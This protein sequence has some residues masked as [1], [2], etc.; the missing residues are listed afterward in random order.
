MAQAIKS[1][2]SSYNKCNR[3]S[4][5]PNVTDAKAKRFGKFIALLHVQI[6]HGTITNWKTI[7][8]ND[9]QNFAQFWYMFC[10][11]Q[12]KCSDFQINAPNETKLLN[13]KMDVDLKSDHQIMKIWTKFELLTFVVGL[14]LFFGYF[15]LRIQLQRLAARKCWALHQCQIFVHINLAHKLVSKMSYSFSDRTAREREKELFYFFWLRLIFIFFFIFTISTDLSYG[16]KLSKNW[17][18]KVASSWYHSTENDKRACRTVS[19]NKIAIFF[20]LISNMTNKLKNRLPYFICCWISRY[21]VPY[22]RWIF[23]IFFNC[24][25]F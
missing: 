14:P 13:S 25:C 20:H 2:I 4:W 5:T 21:S 16:K 18:I 24:I 17:R 8:T 7:V 19:C 23:S 3:I 1:I 15:H 11:Y 9:F 10:W 6:I 22:S 12:S